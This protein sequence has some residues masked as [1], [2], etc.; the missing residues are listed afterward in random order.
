[1]NRA[2]QLNIAMRDVN[3]LLDQ[4]NINPDEFYNKLA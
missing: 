2:V 1:M 3:D 4:N